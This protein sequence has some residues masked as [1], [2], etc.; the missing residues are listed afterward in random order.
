SLRR[1]HCAS[2][3]SLTH[4]MQALRASMRRSLLGGRSVLFPA[5]A[6]LIIT[7]QWAHWTGRLFFSFVRHEGEEEGSLG[8]AQERNGAGFILTK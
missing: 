2:G 1:W 3:E 8:R 6:I 4:R 5:A 7:P